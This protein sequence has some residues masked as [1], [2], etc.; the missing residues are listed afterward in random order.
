M[1]RGLGLRVSEG[2]RAWGSRF[3]VWGLGAGA[4]RGG[5]GGRGE[6]GGG[7]RPTL[8]VA[9]AGFRGVGGNVRVQ[10]LVIGPLTGS[11]IGPNTGIQGSV[12]LEQSPSSYGLVTCFH[13]CCHHTSILSV[14]LIPT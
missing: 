12:M 9:K 1:V 6:R 13:F 8:R 14:Q 5:G 4:G 3:K 7:L 11:L 10:G 2:L